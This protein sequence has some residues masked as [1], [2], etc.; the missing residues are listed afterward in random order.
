M[1]Y[2]IIFF[3]ILILT[4]I[5]ISIPSYAQMSMNNAIFGVGNSPTHA[6]INFTNIFNIQ[7]ISIVNNIMTMT[8]TSTSMSTGYLFYS[9]SNSG[10]INTTLTTATAQWSNFT[11][12]NNNVV[13]DATLNV[14]NAAV[15]NLYLNGVLLDSNVHQIAYIPAGTGSFAVLSLGNATKVSIDFTGATPFGQQPNTGGGGNGPA[16]YPTQYPPNNGTCQY[17]I[18]PNGVCMPSPTSV[19]N[20]SAIP[21]GIHLYVVPNVLHISAGEINQ[22]TFQVEWDGPKQIF[23]TNI[24][25]QY[26]TIPVTFD[27]IP[28]ELDSGS[29]FS[30]RNCATINFVPNVGSNV[31][32]DI[33]T[34]PVSV[35][36]TSGPITEMASGTI[37]IDTRPDQTFLGIIIGAIVAIGA[38]TLIIRSVRK[39]RKTKHE[40]LKNHQQV[41]KD[42]KKIKDD[43]LTKPSKEE[44]D[45]GK[46]LKKS[47]KKI[48]KERR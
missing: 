45:R 37:Q 10:T 18:F 13:K 43:K 28:F 27:H 14:T 29:C 16:T 20:A 3:S 2:R 39:Q 26:D 47:L 34:I 30:F 35:T 11:M 38:L 1:L 36:A 31:A 6:V 48:E 24:I 46:K 40:K 7:N 21:T 44:K 23:I 32:P 22:H 15:H 42:D 5:C 4:G 8:S 12:N 9:P 25:A 41:L 19:G 33:Y 17:G